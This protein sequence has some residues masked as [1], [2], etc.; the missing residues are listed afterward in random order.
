MTLT[1]LDRAYERNKEERATANR[2]LDQLNAAQDEIRRLLKLIEDADHAY[3][4]PS[5]HWRFGKPC[6]CWKSRV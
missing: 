4:C 5:V 1:E 3:N 2:L 6:N